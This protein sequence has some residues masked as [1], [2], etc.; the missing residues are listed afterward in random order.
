MVMIRDCLQL[1]MAI[2]LILTNR[3]L[4]EISQMQKSLS[5]VTL[6]HRDKYRRNHVSGAA[7]RGGGYRRG[8]AG[9]RKKVHNVAHVLF[10]YLGA[11]Y[12]L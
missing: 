11:V 9:D 3:K 8:M 7:G 1:Y 4:S 2:E 6:S 5:S 12:S 10:L